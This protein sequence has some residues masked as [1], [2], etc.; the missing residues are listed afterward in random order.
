MIHVRDEVLADIHAREELLDAAMGEGRFRKTSER[1]REGR[2]PAHDLS[3]I[4]EDHAG[5]IAGTVRLWNVDAG[6][7]RPSLLLGPLAV[8]PD[9]QAGGIGSML[10]RVALARA[11]DLGHRSVLLVGDAPY[12]ARFGFTAASTAKLRLPGPYERARFLAREFV[13]GALVGAA[14]LVCATGTRIPVPAFVAETEVR[15]AA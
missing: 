5:R 8:A 6:A 3:L 11:A 4:A 1:L 2:L 10:M 12:Y 13:P 9:Q 15:A 14:G 7:D